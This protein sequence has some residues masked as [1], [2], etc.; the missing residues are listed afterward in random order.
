MDFVTEW[1]PI[2][3]ITVRQDRVESTGLMTM[4][5]KYELRHWLALAGIASLPLAA[6]VGIGADAIAGGFFASVG[7]L[8]FSVA[9]L[10]VPELPEAVDD[11]NQ[12]EQ[13]RRAS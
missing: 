6:V 3:V 11:A 13:D 8:M 10:L 2:H 12:F 4:L 7:I 5:S 9:T 1:R